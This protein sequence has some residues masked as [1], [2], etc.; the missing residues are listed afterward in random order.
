[1]GR[2][3]QGYGEEYNVKKR[4][5]G[6]HHHLPCDIKAV[7]K[8]KVEKREKGNSKFGEKNKRF[9]EMGVGRISR[10]W[11]ISGG[12]KIDMITSRMLISD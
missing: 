10:C 8:K 6:R 11:M 1:M 7:G 9:Y 12:C 5:K 2:E 4:K 3:Y